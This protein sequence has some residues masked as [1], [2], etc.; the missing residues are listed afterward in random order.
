M[1]SVAKVRT[2]IIMFVAKQSR[3]WMQH[4]KEWWDI[5][6]AQ[7]SVQGLPF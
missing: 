6:Q 1:L 7:P 2:H 4:S 3:K 5:P